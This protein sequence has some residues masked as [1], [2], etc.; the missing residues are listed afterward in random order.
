[1]ADEDLGTAEGSASRIGRRTRSNWLLDA[2]MAGA[3]VAT[4]AGPIAGIGAA[5]GRGIMSRRLDQSQLDQMAQDRADIE[6]ANQD[7]DKQLQRMGNLPGVTDLDREQLNTLQTQRQI[8]ARMMNSSDPNARAQAQNRYLELMDGADSWLNDVESRQEGQQDALRGTYGDAFKDLRERFR[9]TQ[10]T[11]LE[12][13]RASNELLSFIDGMSDNELNKPFNRQRIAALMDT[14][15]R[16]FNIDT[17]DVLDAAGTAVSGIGGAAAATPWG[18]AAGAASGLINGLLQGLK[19]ED[20]KIKSSDVRRVAMKNIQSLDEVA[21]MKL[22]R[23]GEEARALSETGKRF[24]I[25]ADDDSVFGYVTGQTDLAPVTAPQA[26]QDGTASSRPQQQSRSSS[27]R[28]NVVPRQSGPNPA[29]AALLAQEVEAPDL[30][31]APDAA[32]VL[33]AIRSR[34][35][36]ND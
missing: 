13:K 2:I 16:A 25:V 22:S 23:Y 17:P 3:G 27:V 33:N 7:V 5:I 15:A 9:G 31:R 4:V 34:R 32:A 8:L 21:Q 28:A 26:T 36:T 11:T 1:M 18:A 6:A 35:P 30:S 24:G 14:S 19:A 10:D 20:F 29:Q 12:A